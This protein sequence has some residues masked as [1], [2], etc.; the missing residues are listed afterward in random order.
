MKKIT[1]IL[2]DKEYMM[3]LF[4][5]LIFGV[6]TTIVGLGSFWLLRR[7]LPQIEENLANAISIILAIVFAYFTNRKYVFKSKEKNMFK[8]F[9]AFASSRGLTFAF[10]MA[11]FFIFASVLNYNEMIVKTII[12]IAVILLNYIISKVYVFKGVKEK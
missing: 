9:V 12:S 8:E 5:Y 1:E 4:V 11:S 6:L 3:H 2:N 10:D 7:H